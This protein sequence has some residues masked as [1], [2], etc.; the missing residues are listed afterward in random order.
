MADDPVADDPV[1]IARGLI[2]TRFRLHGRGADGLDC[3]GLVAV[4]FGEDAVPVGYR[5]HTASLAPLSEELA[6]RGFVVAT[7]VTRGDVVAFR[8]GPA[9][10]HLGLWTGTALIHADAGIGR[11]VETPGAPSWATIGIWRKGG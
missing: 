8:P 1:A 4:A 11:V 9:Q 5:L 6:A 7:T 3:I 10:L 2:G